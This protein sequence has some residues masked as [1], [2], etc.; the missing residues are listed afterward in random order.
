[1]FQA[2]KEWYKLY[3]VSIILIVLYL[4]EAYFKIIDFTAGLNTQIP[5]TIKLILLIVV[6]I[7]ICYK[8][9]KSLVLPFLVLCCFC[10]GQWFLTKGFQYQII[11]VL[12]KLLYPIILLLFFNIYKLSNPQKRVVFS[13][14]EMLIIFNSFLVLLGL[15]LD[16]K[17]F[18][19][20]TG[21]RFGYNGLLITSATS[22]YVYAISLM[23]L[24]MKYKRSFFVL[25]KNYLVLFAALCVGTKVLYLF[26][27]GLLFVFILEYI[28]KKTRLFFIAIFFLAAVFVGYLFFFQVGIFNNIRQDSGLFTAIMSYRDQLFLEQ[29]LPFIKSNWQFV[30]YLFGGINSVVL[31]S[32]IDFVDVFAFFG[33]LGGVLYI[34]S[35]YKA[36]VTFKPNFVTS[37]LLL[38]LLFIVFLAGNFFSY[39]SIAIYLVILREYLKYNEQSKHT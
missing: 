15:C 14:F 4:S 3:F 17:I 35:Y 26:I 10:I 13:T 20:Y 23:Y 39:P 5:R 18:N 27:L 21:S 12:G 24:Y 32:Q 6:C 1:M 38:I 36:F 22:S 28:N 7:V 34:F 19:T 25:P 8:N 29:T 16:I 11:V 30:N 33:L 2:I 9:I 31:R 37:F